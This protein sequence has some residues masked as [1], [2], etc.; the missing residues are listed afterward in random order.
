MLCILVAGYATYVFERA[1][2]DWH[3][4]DPD[5]ALKEGAPNPDTPITMA[6]SM[7]F[8]AVTAGTVGYGQYRCH[9]FVGRA[10]AVVSV[11]VGIFGV[12]EST[13]QS[14]STT[15]PHLK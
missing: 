12:G 11:C 8:I 6:N 15:D 3:L 9:T 14:D 10:L 1:S 7:W 4:S 13:V 5:W 2:D